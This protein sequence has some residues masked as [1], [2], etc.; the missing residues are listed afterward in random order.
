MLKHHS[1]WSL[2]RLTARSSE[3]VRHNTL[4]R[5]GTFTTLCIVH[6]TYCLALNTQ[7]MITSRLISARELH[8]D[9]SLIEY[10]IQRTCLR[11][12]YNIIRIWPVTSEDFITLFQDHVYIAD[13]YKSSMACML[14]LPS[15]KSCRNQL[16][17]LTC[18]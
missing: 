10:I 2:E 13:M 6:C 12:Y 17:H 9:T 1:L 16:F 11:I 3:R 5:Y 4:T 8:L 7:I 18:C 14:C 15:Y